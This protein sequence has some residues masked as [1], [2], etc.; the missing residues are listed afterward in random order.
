MIF[1]LFA[2][3][4]FAV[5]EWF[6]EYKK[7]RLGIYLTKP[8]TM[9]LLIIWL[10]FFAD[11][12]L[13]ISGVNSSLVVWFI[14][15]LL[16]CLGGDVFLMLPERFFMP[17]LISFLA[18]HLCYIIGFGM[19]IPPPGSEMVAT[20]IAFLLLF[21][22][23]WVYV[24][25]ASGMRTTGKERMRLPVL[26][27]TVVIVLMLF[28]ALMTLFNNE[29]DVLPA[30]LVSIGALLFLVSDIVN[31]WVRF[32]ARIPNHRLWIMSTYHFAQI[33]ITGVYRGVLTNL[34]TFILYRHLTFALFRPATIPQ[35]SCKTGKA[36]TYKHFFLGFKM[37]MFSIEDRVKCVKYCNRFFVNSLAKRFSTLWYQLLIN[38]F[39]CIY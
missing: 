39:Y 30:V 1:I 9:F 23:G 7:N 38:E 3:L 21:I 6:F 31:A 37:F 34:R 12:P 29:W 16:F 11:V 33:F 19:P 22:A 8:T 14:L 2:V 13:L 36:I 18:G 20:L 27:Y 28:S 25:L 17:G 26:F 15:G 35:K 4:I 32:V 10:W 24:R 5:L